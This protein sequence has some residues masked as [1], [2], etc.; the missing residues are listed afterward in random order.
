MRNRKKIKELENKIW[1]LENPPKPI[2]TVVNLTVNNKSK[3][4]IVVDFEFLEAERTHFLKPFG[5]PNRWRYTLYD[6]EDKKTIY[7]VM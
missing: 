3:P 6:K 4:Y 7:R 1:K 5:I 2:G